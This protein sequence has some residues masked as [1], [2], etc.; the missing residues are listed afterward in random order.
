MTPLLATKTYK[1]GPDRPGVA[2]SVPDQTVDAGLVIE[3]LLSIN[4]LARI[5]GCSRRAVE[6]MRSTGKLPPPTLLI[7]SKC[8]RWKP[9]VIRN[10]I[11]AGGQ[12]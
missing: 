10:W 11:E 9:Q 8:P 12:T 5:M 6:R 7:G 4:D 2:D 3:R 1:P